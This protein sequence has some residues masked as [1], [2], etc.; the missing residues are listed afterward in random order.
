LVYS[1]R[2]KLSATEP[3]KFFDGT[4]AML[5]EEEPEEGTL[6]VKYTPGTRQM[7][8]NGRPVSLATFGSI[9]EA[10][11]PKMWPEVLEPRKE[12]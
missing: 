1:P 2:V 3:P 8:V 10:I 7:T 6:N 9:N 11:Y 12:T 5:C 4:T